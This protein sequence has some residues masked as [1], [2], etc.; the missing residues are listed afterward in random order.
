MRVR[1]VGMLEVPPEIK[2]DLI[3]ENVSGPPDNCLIYPSLEAFYVV[4]ADGAIRGK[5]FAQPPRLLYLK[6]HFRKGVAMRTYAI[7]PFWSVDPKFSGRTI[8][9]LS[10]TL[11]IPPFGP[12]DQYAFDY[13]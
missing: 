7:M 1:V 2:F 6:S 12:I 9:S 3:V 11:F 4:E 5:Y 8:K 13:I 10:W